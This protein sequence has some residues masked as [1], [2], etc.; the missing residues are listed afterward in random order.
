M[1]VSKNSG[2]LFEQTNHHQSLRAGVVNGGID[3]IMKQ[4]ED[5]RYK[6]VDLPY[7][8]TT[9]SPLLPDTILD[10]HAHAWEADQWLTP[11][12]VSNT[13]HIDSGSLGMHPAAR[14]MSTQL[15][16]SVDQLLADG[17]RIFPDKTYQA[18]FFGQPTPA[19]DLAKTN[20][21]I[22]EQARTGQLFPLRVT[23]KDQV[24]QEQLRQELL[25]GKFFGYKVFLDWIGNDYGHIQIED[26]IGSQEMQLADEYHLIVLLHVPG[27]RRLADPA[28]QRGVQILAQQYPNAQ[29]VLA[30]CG[31]CYLPAEMKEAIHA[32]QPL[33]NVYLDT[34]MVMDSTVLQ[35]VFNHIDSSRVLFATDFPI[36]AM[37]GRRVR[38]MD[39][40][41]DVVLDGYPESDFRVASDQIHASF[42][43][44]EIV[45]AITTAAEMAGLKPG[46]VRDIFYN[47]GMRLLHSV[48]ID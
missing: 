20:R 47:N 38:V 42:M 32:I 44:Y 18:V 6:S 14:Y 27:A 23:G 7:Y 35:I 40:W 31:R 29:I 39:H 25:S 30:H 24:S 13:D 46:A 41:V 22:A 21:S 3:T 26:M 16:Y 28:I 48:Q 17:K 33:N 11:P 2:T 45:L 4:P 1:T 43:A 19:I 5:L 15:T 34:S 36:A 37:R 9:I 8:Q 12:G 10:F